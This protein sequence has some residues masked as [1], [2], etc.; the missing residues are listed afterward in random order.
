MSTANAQ[1]GSATENR[2]APEITCQAPA[3]R[4]R[5]ESCQDQG[6]LLAQIPDLDSKVT[7]NVPGKWLDGRIISQALSIKLIF[8]LGLGLVIGAILPFLFGKVSRPGPVV[9]E[10]PAWSCNGGSTGTA[11]NT[12]QSMAPTWSPSSITPATAGVSPQ[13]A[14]GPAILLP[15]PPLLGATRPTAPTEPA[16]MQAR[17]F[18]APGSAATFSPLR[19]DNIHPPLA[20]TN[21]PGNPIDSRGFDRDSQADPLRGRPAPD[22][23]NLQADTRNDAAGPYRNNDTR[24]DY[25]GNTI[26]PVPVGRDVPAGGYSRD[27]NYDNGNGNYRAATGPGSPLMPSS[28]QGPTPAYSAPPVSEPGIARFEGTITP[29][30]VRTSYDRAGSSNY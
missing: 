25:R 16:W 27:A 23:R 19:N 22:G 30:P 14:P 12:S 1:N 7:P 15:Q 20:N 6:A 8:G 2:T 28:P 4:P 18:V 29:P 17:Q 5:P 21:L 3:H 26:G 10:L 24:Y 13:T 11:G 9:T